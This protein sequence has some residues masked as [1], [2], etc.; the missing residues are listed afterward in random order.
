MR[1]QTA[2]VFLSTIV[3][4]LPRVIV[5]QTTSLF[6]VA[7]LGPAALAVLARPLALLQHVSTLMNKYAFVLTPMAGSIQ[8]I[9]DSAELRRFVFRHARTGWIFAIP[10]SF[11]PLWLNT[12]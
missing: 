9:Q 4:A 2:L 5:I 8:G 10:P 1:R 7:S 3:L 12:R 6:I 11:R